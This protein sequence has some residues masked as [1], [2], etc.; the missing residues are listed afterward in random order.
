MVSR[1]LHPLSNTAL[2]AYDEQSRRILTFSTWW[3][4]LSRF[5]C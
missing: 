3:A 5:P 2:I 4:L 1:S